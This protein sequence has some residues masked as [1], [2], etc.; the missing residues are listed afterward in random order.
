VE[1][2]YLLYPISASHFEENK[3]IV[4]LLFA[5]FLSK[6]KYLDSFGFFGQRFVSCLPPVKTEQASTLRTAAQ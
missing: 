4:Q 3:K 6:M 2:K 1:R 5:L